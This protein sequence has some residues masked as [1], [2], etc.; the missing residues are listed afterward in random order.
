MRKSWWKVRMPMTSKPLWT[1]MLGTTGW[2]NA[3]TTRRKQ[4]RNAGNC[5]SLGVW[6]R[7]SMQSSTGLAKN[8]RVS[9][10]P[11]AS[12]RPLA[13]IRAESGDSASKLATSESLVWAWHSLTM[14]DLFSM[15]FFLLM[16]SVRLKSITPGAVWRWSTAKLLLRVFVLEHLVQWSSLFLAGS[17]SPGGIWRSTGESHDLF[18][19]NHR[20]GNL[21]APWV[22]NGTTIEINWIWKCIG[23]YFH[24]CLLYKLIFQTCTVISY[25]SSSH[26]FTHII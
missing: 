5:G 7:A 11:A 19:S 17:R 14:L 23:N 25:I 13:E 6:L 10:N 12:L 2:C 15:L 20:M 26:F 4:S 1:Q 18:K 9:W 22:A 21:E 24:H 8:M 3:K 16:K